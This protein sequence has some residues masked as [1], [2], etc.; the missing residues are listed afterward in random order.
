MLFEVKTSKSF[1]KTMKCTL[2]LSVYVNTDDDIDEKYHT[3][4]LEM[5]V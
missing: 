4:D 2:I 3:N 1:T 5:T